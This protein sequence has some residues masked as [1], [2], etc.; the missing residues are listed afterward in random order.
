LYRPAALP[1]A[2]EERPAVSH[3][4]VGNQIRRCVDGA[5]HARR[6]SCRALWRRR[7]AALSEV[8]LEA[9]RAT[10]KQPACIKK[11]GVGSTPKPRL[12]S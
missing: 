9:T 4:N 1:A 7:E 11:V 10:G 5:E 6:R 2:L 8:E 3:N 12:T